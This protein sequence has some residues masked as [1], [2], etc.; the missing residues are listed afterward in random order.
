ML[1]RLPKYPYPV[2]PS[3]EEMLDL[4]EV[5]DLDLVFLLVDVFE[6]DLEI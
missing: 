3:D 1:Q 4:L 5:E 2:N 6:A